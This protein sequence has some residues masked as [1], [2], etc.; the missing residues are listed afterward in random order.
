[1]TPMVHTM[2]STIERVYLSVDG[3][4]HPLAPLETVSDIKSQVLSAVRAQGG[5]VNVTGDAGQQIS[6][7]VTAVT[8]IT[9]T[10]LK[11]E[12]ND[13]AAAQLQWTMSE[14]LADEGD[15][16]YDLI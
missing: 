11:L 9:V 4:S 3:R 10:A 14:N 1:M 7:L 15:S 12:V 5:F 16:P 2:S 8:S 6:V 13:E